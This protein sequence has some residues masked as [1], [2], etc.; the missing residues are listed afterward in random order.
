MMLSE[1][2]TLARDEARE[3][4]KFAQQEN[5]VLRS[6]N[7]GLNEE[8]ADVRAKLDDAHNKLNYVYK[9]LDCLIAGDDINVDLDGNNNVDEDVARVVKALGILKSCFQSGKRKG[10]GGHVKV[11]LVTDEGKKLYIHSNKNNNIFVPDLEK[12][13]GKT[14]SCLRVSH[15]MTGGHKDYLPENGYI[16]SP[17]LG[18]S[19]REYQVV[20]MTVSPALGQGCA[21]G[22]RG[23]HRT[24]PMF[25]PH[26]VGP[27]IC[28]Q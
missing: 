2:L 5:K 4:M 27:R 14:V 17:V 13:I 23:G 26:V 11:N 19:D 10:Q 20:T 18:W 16:D 6:R 22:Q 1:E 12:L 7:S 15:V 24:G 3:K 8:A 9:A 21:P 25:P 28:T